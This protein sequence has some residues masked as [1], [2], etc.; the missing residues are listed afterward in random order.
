MASLAHL[1]V[2]IIFWHR[3]KADYSRFAEV[4]RGGHGGEA[5]AS[6][7]L[8]IDAELARM[9]RAGTNEPD[10]AVGLVPEKLSGASAEIGL[11]RIELEAGQLCDAVRKALAM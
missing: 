3:A 9:D 2:N 8:G 6:E 1:E 11:R 4:L 5:E 10:A 7:L